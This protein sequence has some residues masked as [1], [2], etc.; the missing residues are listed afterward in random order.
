M[1]SLTNN[2]SH[3]AMMVSCPAIHLQTHYCRISFLQSPFHTHDS[4]LVS[5][6]FLIKIQNQVKTTCLLQ[7]SSIVIGTPYTVVRVSQTAEHEEPRPVSE[8]K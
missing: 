5:L 4:F 6:N 1:A 7:E 2:S 8:C 3:I